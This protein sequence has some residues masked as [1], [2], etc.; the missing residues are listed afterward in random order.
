V[1]TNEPTDPEKNGEAEARPLAALASP[2]A[3]RELVY[4]YL[5]DLTV[6]QSIARGVLRF[7]ELTKYLKMEDSLGRR[8]DAECAVSFP[9]EEYRTQP[10]KLPV[11]S[12][13]GIQFHCISTGVD[14]EY[15]SQ[16]FVLCTSTPGANRA[17][18][19]GRYRVELHRD[20]FDL[21]SQLLNPSTKPYLD[22]DGRKL[23]SHGPVEYYD[24]DH[25]PAPIPKDRWKEVF[26]KHRTFAHQ[27]EYRA[28]LFLSKQTFDR[29]REGGAEIRRAVHHPETRE[30]MPFDLV[31][32]V[33]AGLDHDGWRYV[34]I[35]TSAFREH[36]GLDPAVIVDL[37]QSGDDAALVEAKHG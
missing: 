27:R 12:F 31:F 20:Q 9:E 33:R 32:S 10:E 6:A 25:H 30:R 15:V 29:T 19:D 18:G 11:A 35:D 5:S 8:D 24:I 16:Y 14:Q 26:L 2:A 28:A 22:Q 21:L 3:E 1:P 4:R 36:L 34:E 37:D 23:F 13:K 7:Y 17:I